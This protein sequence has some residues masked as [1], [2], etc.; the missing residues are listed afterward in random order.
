MRVTFVN[1]QVLP[2][3]GKGTGKQPVTKHAG[4][5]LG[6]FPALAVGAGLDAQQILSN[7]KCVHCQCKL[8]APVSWV[9]ITPLSSI[10]TR[11]HTGTKRVTVAGSTSHP[12]TQLPAHRP[13]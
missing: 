13:A 10:H 12:V 3:Q 6:G 11:L 9:A 1:L 2:V 4:C 8:P 7:P 5:E